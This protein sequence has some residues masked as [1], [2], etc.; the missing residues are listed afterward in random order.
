MT[1]PQQNATIT[2]VAGAGTSDDWDR[3]GGAGAA[4]WEGARRAYYRAST[5]REVGA[6]GAT[7]IVTKRELIVAV[8]WV[9]TTGLDLDDV[10]TFR[11]DGDTTDSTGTAQAVPRAQLATIPGRLQTSRIRLENA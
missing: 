6:A 4:K 10:I 11:V 9:L 2:A 3:P 8:E 5:T 1:V 7:D